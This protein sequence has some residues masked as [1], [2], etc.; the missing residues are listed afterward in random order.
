MKS[1][2]EWGRVECGKTNAHEDGHGGHVKGTARE[3]EVDAEDVPDD[4]ID[5]M[6][7]AYVRT[8]ELGEGGL[9]ALSPL[10]A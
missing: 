5:L 8:G 7:W 6:L 4:T 9:D 1:Q 2:N 3:G 10:P